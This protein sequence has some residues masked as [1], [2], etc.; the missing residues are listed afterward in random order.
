MDLY[1]LRK[2][3]DKS[4]RVDITGKLVDTSSDSVLKDSETYLTST[5]ALKVKQVTDFPDHSLVTV[6]PDTITLYRADS[7]ER[8]DVVVTDIIVRNKISYLLASTSDGAEKMLQL[9][10]GEV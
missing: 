10:G 8:L 3:V 4:I 5:F 1:C 2:N 6:V 7:H 9:K